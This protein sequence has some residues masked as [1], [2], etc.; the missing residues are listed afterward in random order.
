MHHGLADC[1]TRVDFAAMFESQLFEYLEFSVRLLSA[2]KFLVSAIC[3]LIISSVLFF[4]IHNIHVV[5][6]ICVVQ[7][8]TNSVLYEPFI[9]SITFASISPNAQLNLC[10]LFVSFTPTG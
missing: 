10:L 8:D 3:P 4:R 9:R 2:R 7:V 6:V 1:A 5:S